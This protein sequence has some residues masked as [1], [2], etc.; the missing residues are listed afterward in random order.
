M[1]GE[2]QPMLLKAGPEIPAPRVSWRPFAR[3]VP[4]PKTTPFT[5]GYLVLLLGTTLLLKFADPA[6]TD[7]LLQLSSTDA[8]NLW[9]RPLTSLLTSALWL[10]DEG[11]LAYVVIFAIAVAPLER[12][13]G[14]RRAATVFFSGHVLATLVT[15]LPV[16]ALISAHV[17]PNSAGHWLDIGVS[18]GFFT[19]AGALVF[20]LRGRLRLVALAVTEAFIAAIWLSDDPW[21][22]DSI[23]TLLGHAFAAH[24]GLVF[25]GPRLRRASAGRAGIP[26]G[27]QA[28]ESVV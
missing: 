22:L 18:Y 10:S 6:L 16:M 8:H 13:F 20:L 27:R 4:S 26:A 3:F 5:F 24:F 15:E 21:V 1:T 11:W 14:A 7:R 28:P 2:A 19:T 12:R 9:R 25:W 23:V 17:L